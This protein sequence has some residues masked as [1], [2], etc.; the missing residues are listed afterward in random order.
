[1]EDD[2]FIT[3]IK[4]HCLVYLLYSSYLYNTGLNLFNE[5]F[6][7]DNGCPKV[8]NLWYKFDCYKNNVIKSYA[9]NSIEEIV[10]YK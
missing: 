10:F 4:L 1:M 9:V 8:P 6:V 3:L 2:C 5:P 7:L